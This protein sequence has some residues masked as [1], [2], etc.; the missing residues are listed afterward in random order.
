MPIP[1]LRQGHKGLKA[2]KKFRATSPYNNAVPRKKERA[3]PPEATSN[4]GSS[5]STNAIVNSARDIGLELSVYK[6]RYDCWYNCTIVGF[7]RKRRMHCCQY[8][9][10][11]KQW[12][13]LSGHKAKVIGRSDDSS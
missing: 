1:I 7:D 9:C 13:D 2:L 11:D 12:Q 6:F 8:D 4:G 10:G 5:Q 3:T